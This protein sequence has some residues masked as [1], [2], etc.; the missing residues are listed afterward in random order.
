MAFQVSPGVNVSEIDA[1][2]GIPAVSV[3]T[4]GMAGAFSWGPILQI[5]TLSSEVE[6]AALHGRPDANSAN[7]FFS[8]ANFLAYS[9][10]LKVVRADA[11]GARNATANGAGA[12]IRNADEYFNGSYQ[13]TAPNSWAARYAGDL[14]NSLK[15]IVFANNSGWAANSSNVSDPLYNFANQCIDL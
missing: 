3:S 1:T 15:V 11:T 13:S 8:A 9:N 5:N 12:L 4:G 7:A 6:L 14:G 10:D 2:T